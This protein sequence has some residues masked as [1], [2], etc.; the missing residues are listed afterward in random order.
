MYVQRIL[1][2]LLPRDVYFGIE[3]S[4]K[5]CSATTGVS[6]DSVKPNTNITSQTSPVNTGLQAPAPTAEGP[7]MSLNTNTNR[8]YN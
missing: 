5:A 1:K 2:S 6:L 3:E 7:A 8:T 4:W